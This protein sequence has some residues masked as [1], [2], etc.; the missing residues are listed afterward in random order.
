MPL[1]L[2][3]EIFKIFVLAGRLLG[4]CVAAMPC[5][6]VDGATGCRVFVCLCADMFVVR[7]VTVWRGGGQ[8]VV[9]PRKRGSPSSV[10]LSPASPL[11]ELESRYLPVTCRGFVDAPAIRRQA[12][13]SSALSCV[14]CDLVCLL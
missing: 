6:G 2:E 10:S 5:L 8:L 3:T 9:S 1:L 7:A 14:L 12:S 11:I 13:A 4:R